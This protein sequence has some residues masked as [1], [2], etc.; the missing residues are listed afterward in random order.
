MHRDGLD[1]VPTRRRDSIIDPSGSTSGWLARVTPLQLIGLMGTLALLAIWLMRRKR[2]AG[3]PARL[4]RTRPVRHLAGAGSGANPGALAPNQSGPSPAAPLVT[5]IAPASLVDFTWQTAESLPESRAEPMLAELQK[6]PPPPRAFYQLVAPDFV[7]AA[8]S[9]ELA[10]LV[11][12]VPLVATK[13]LARANSAYYRPQRPVSSVG[14]AITLLGLN[15]VRAICL[16][17]MME[18][19]FKAHTPELRQRFDQLWAASA[20]AGELSQK[21]AQRLQLPDAGSLVTEVALSSLGHFAAA[22]LM[23][24][25]SAAASAQGLLTRTWSE[26]AQLGV[27]AAEVGVLLMRAWALPEVLIE[28]VRA[29]DRMLVTPAGQLEPQHYLR[30]AVGYLSARLGER[31]ARGDAVNLADFDETVVAGD[32][33]FHLRSSLPALQQQRLRDA[34]QAPDIARSVETM[35]AA[36]REPGVH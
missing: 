27:P 3:L 31:L 17:Y 23:P 4:P 33:F 36:L 19:S 24:H 26:Q 28:E 14:Q 2:H 35:L 16:Q 6:T 8:S 12:S 20:I 10:E 13:V 32:D 7:A 9:A 5:T 11:I 15:S 22:T 21:L 1:Y 30:L 25:S 34:L 18:A 29:I